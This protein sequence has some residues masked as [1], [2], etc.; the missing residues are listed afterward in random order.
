MELDALGAENNAF[1]SNEFTG[2]YAKAAKKHF[3]KLLDIVSDLYLNPTVPEKDLETERGVILQEISMY[4]DLPQSKVWDVLGKLMYGDTPHGRTIL[5]PKD[6]IKKFT[7][8]DFVNYRN[9][10]Y[11]A[12]KTFV[13][14]AG[15]V[16]ES[17][18]M[19]EVKKRFNGIANGKKLGKDKVV[20]KQTKPAMLLE[21][22]KTDQTHMVLGFR[23]FGAKDKRVPA[24]DLVAEVLGRGMSSRLFRKL[25]DEMGACYY[26]KARAQ[27]LTDH[28]VLAI[29]TGIEAK[30]AEEVL[31]AILDEVRRICREPVAPEELAKAKEHAIGHLYMGLETTDSLS[32]FYAEQEVVTGKPK[33]PQE[34]EKAIRKLTAK[35]VMKVAQEIFSNPGLN[36]AIVGDIKNPEALKKAL[37]I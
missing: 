11:I 3:S 28:G 20:E 14:I 35:D 10:H 18:A 4:E 21:Y 9:A 19:A 33:T 1:T 15:D 36:L 5:G 32:W 25:R 12:N 13:I 30:R 27:E 8:D 31:K 34:V 16:S 22:K 7:R 17:K 2:Y 26:V 23:T 29:S 6:N 37:K 24:V